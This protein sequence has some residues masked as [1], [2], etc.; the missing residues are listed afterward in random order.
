MFGGEGGLFFAN[1]GVLDASRFS[2]QGLVACVQRFLF[3]FDFL[4]S[5][6]HPCTAGSFRT[7][8][9]FACNGVNLCCDAGSSEDL[10][11][12]LVL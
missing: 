7:L 2:P 1:L 10:G 3:D 6:F 9:V 8:F 4:Q 11:P 12:V 5:L